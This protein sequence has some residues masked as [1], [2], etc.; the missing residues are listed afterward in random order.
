MNSL[1]EAAGNVVQTC[2]V[3]DDL[4]EAMARW[5]HT[6]G[7]GP[8]HV[9]R[10]LELDVIH[11]GTPRKLAMSIGL[12]QIGGVHVELIQQHDAGPSVYRDSF[13]NGG[14][15]FHHVAMLVPDVAA[16]RDF[17]TGT[18]FEIAMSIQFG[19][20]PVLYIDTRA[21]LGCMVEV[22]RNDR[23]IVD[24]YETVR[25]TAENWDGADPIRDLPH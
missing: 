16:A 9:F 19:E 21:V 11:R 8:F 5:Q 14:G 10:H 3:V 12:A 6:G 13:P 2:F 24:L 1:F 20:T 22:L 4:E 18:G 15:G 17:Y 7:A 23:Q 25:A